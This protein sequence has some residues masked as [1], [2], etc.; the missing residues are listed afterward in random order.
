MAKSKRLDYLINQ[1]RRESENEE[2][3]DTSGIGD[4]EFIQYIND[5]QHRLQALIT[6]QH[7]KVFVVEAEQNAVV[8]QES[9]DI[10][11]DCFLA[12]RITNVEYTTSTTDYYYNLEPATQKRRQPAIAG[13]PRL[14]IRRSGDILLSP[15]PDQAGSIRINYVKQLPELDVR[16]GSVD[17][18]VLDTVNRTIT[19]L[20]LNV[21][22]DTVDGTSL[23]EHDYLCIVDRYGNFKMKNIPVDSVNEGSGVVTVT[24]GFVYESGETIDSGDYV[25]GG[26]YTTTHSE[27]PRHC[28]RYLVKYCVWKIL[29]RDSSVDYA[30][31]QE[32]LGGI[33][34]EIID[35]YADI[36]DDI[37]YIPVLNAW[38]DWS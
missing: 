31:A 3:S 26:S 29:K 14:Y 34:Q 33:A 20:T 16:R 13:L 30:E 37:T 5:A 36:S 21:T 32:E 10:P 24:A 18:A 11:E 15:K 6:A 9:Y 19:S 27:L 1:A 25:V 17:T 12:N 8:G 7:P 35:S 38:E 2:F 22:T 23:A 4:E 28:E